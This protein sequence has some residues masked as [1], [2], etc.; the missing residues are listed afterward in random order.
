[1]FLT[2]VVTP[3]GAGSQSRNWEAWLVFVAIRQGLDPKLAPMVPSTPF[4]ETASSVIG[5][6]LYMKLWHQNMLSNSF[7][8]TFSSYVSTLT[9]LS[10]GQHIVL[11]TKI[12]HSGPTVA[13]CPVQM[14]RSQ[15][16]S[17]AHKAGHQHFRRRYLHQQHQAKFVVEDLHRHSFHFHRQPCLEDNL[18]SKRLY[19]TCRPIPN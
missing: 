16:D 14:R 1:M 10:G 8:Y 4:V 12:L 9:H 11:P 6:V 2:W 3:H 18:K 5:G 15:L 19:F 7:D 17:S 13:T